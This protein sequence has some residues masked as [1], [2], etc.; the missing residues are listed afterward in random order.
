MNYGDAHSQC[1]QNTI[2]FH[3]MGDSPI[4]VRYPALHILKVVI[5][6]IHAPM[7]VCNKWTERG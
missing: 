1:D 7:Y 2:P 3:H 6:K 4:R 5:Q